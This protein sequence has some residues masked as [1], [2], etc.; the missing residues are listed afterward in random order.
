M[1]VTF[2]GT[3]T[4]VGVPQ[5]A[6]ECEVCLSDNQKNKRTRSSVLVEYGGRS[7]LIDATPELRLQALSVGMKRLD[8]ILFTHAH[9]DHV[10]GLDDVR[11]FNMRQKE[12][13]PCYANSVAIDDIRH[14]YS[15]IFT[16]TQVGGGKPKIDLI[17]ASGAFDLFGTKVTPLPVKHG[18]LDILGYLM[19]DFAY[20]TDAS[21]I[22]DQ[23]LGLIQG[24]DT[25]VLNALR[26]HPHS[27]HFSVEQALEI[28]ARVAPRQAFLTH[29]GHNIEH[30]AL[31]A[32]LPEGVFLAYDGLTLD[33]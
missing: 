24:V 8:A 22:S 19:G 7:I 16:E 14:Q 27:T 5:I 32:E 18:D 28:I 2:L 21:E 9:A 25:M 4:S 3:G 1:L 20:I 30:E 15:Y 29:I 11:I 33:M 13:I 12:S 23:T 17:E 31:S 10:H 6:C 26:Y